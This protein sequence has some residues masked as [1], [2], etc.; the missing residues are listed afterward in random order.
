MSIFLPSNV[1][2]SFAPPCSAS[3]ILIAC[4]LLQIP[5]D[6]LNTYLPGYVTST[7]SLY[8]TLKNVSI[9]LLV[10]LDS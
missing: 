7:F 4:S 3:C 10:P 5:S 1:K 9:D 2:G 8:N 6:A